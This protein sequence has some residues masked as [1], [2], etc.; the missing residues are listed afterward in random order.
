MDTPRIRGRRWM[1]IRERIFNRDCGLCQECQ[2]NGQLTLATQVDHIIALAN[3]GS[4]DDDNLEC[5]CDDCHDRKTNADLG[6]KPRVVTG[7][8]GWPQADERNQRPVWKRHG[9]R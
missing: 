3:G 1:T 9:Y 6:Y 2:R 8:D 7:L 4:N 5:I